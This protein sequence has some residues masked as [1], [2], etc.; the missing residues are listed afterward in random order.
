MVPYMLLWCEMLRAAWVWM[1]DTASHFRIRVL[2]SLTEAL[3]VH[4]QFVVV[5]TP[6]TNGA[7]ERRVKEVIRTLKSIL[8]EERPLVSDSAHVVSAVHWALN[9]AC[10]VRWGRSP[11][12]IMHGSAPRLTFS[13][14]S[15]PSGGQWRFD[16]LDKQTLLHHVSRLLVTQEE[17]HRRVHADV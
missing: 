6:W 16:G 11:L 13:T 5:Y 2:A 12:H 10:S 4:H 9:T 1:S 15:P 7:R 17:L 14:L 8:S 3:K